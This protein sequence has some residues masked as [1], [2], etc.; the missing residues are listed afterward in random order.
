MTSCHPCVT[1]VPQESCNPWT[2]HGGAVSWQGLQPWR[3]EHIHE[4]VFLAGIVAHGG[5]FQPQAGGKSK[6]HKVLNS[7]E[8]PLLTLL[9][10]SR[11]GDELEESEVKLSLGVRQRRRRGGDAFRFGFISVLL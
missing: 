1:R 4:W 5:H 9:H 11:Q 3:E 2:A 7:L 6:R 8:P 10:C